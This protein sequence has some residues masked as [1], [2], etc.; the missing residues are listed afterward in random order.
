MRDT[1]RAQRAGHAE[2][3]RANA[4][5]RAQVH[6]RLSVVS[7][8]I[9]RRAR[10]GERPQLLLDFLLAR[11]TTHAE[12]SREH[13][14]YVAVENRITHR[15]RQREDRACSRAPDTGQ[16]LYRFERARKLT[17]VLRDDQGCRT[18]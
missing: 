6:D 17:V 1:L 8:A 7:D 14:L 5:D 2:R 18:M 3:P 12:V 4:D 13:A 15:L 11:K 16:R 9:G 10:I